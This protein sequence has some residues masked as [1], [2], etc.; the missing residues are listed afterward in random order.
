A[1]SA[2]VV[3]VFALTFA[4]VHGW[5][6]ALFFVLCVT[7]AWLF[8]GLEASR[9]WRRF[10]PPLAKL[11][12]NAG[13]HAGMAVLVPQ[14]A[15]YFLFGIMFGVIR[16]S[17]AMRREQGL[18]AMVIATSMFAVV[19]LNPGFTFPSIE[20]IWQKGAVL[21]GLL[22]VILSSTVVGISGAVV[23]RRLEETLDQLSEKDRLLELQNGQL[24]TEVDLRT[25]D[26]VAAKE[27]AE[28]ANEA[29]SRFLANMSH[30]IRT[31]LNGIV[32][33]AEI[34]DRRTL[35]PRNC[36]LLDI[37]RD[38]G[39][40]LLTIA[41]DVLDVSKIRQGTFR[42]APVVFDPVAVVDSTL[43]LFGPSAAANGLSMACHVEVP[44]GSRAFGD[45][46]RLRQILTNLVA[47]AIKFTAVGGVTV[48]VTAPTGED[49]N[50]SYSV[51]D[52][53][54]GIVEEQLE[55]IFE[56]F[57]Q[58]DDASNRRYEGTGLGLSIAADLSRLMGGHI[59]VASK[60]GVGSTFTV[61]IPAVAVP[62]GVDENMPSVSVD[63]EATQQEP[64]AYVLVAE[65][66]A[67]NQRVVTAMLSKLGYRFDIAA[68]GTEVMERVRAHRPHV[69]LM[70]C[71]MPEM[72]GYEAT[73]QVREYESTS[74]VQIPVIALTANVA[75]GDRDKCLAAG[76]DDYLAKP[77]KI[78]SLG[79]LLQQ[80]LT[81]RV[82]VPKAS[83]VTS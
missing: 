23:R 73:R 34:L 9:R 6:A 40:S 36:E 48:R 33:V 8:V 43:D 1:V 56:A 24:E 74:G 28:A 67:V 17:M 68:N 52:T 79:A 20:T 76:M 41:N 14:A 19:V 61:V 71:H 25:Q 27:E 44:E 42:L 29:K 72:D 21:Y 75:A 35:D 31:P 62:A 45:A 13:I 70:D 32:G 12:T 46:T 50:W 65:D 51:S 47:N 82:A 57:T 3:A 38:S 64:T 10:A 16:A 22:L 83:G 66:N 2:S 55:T 5:H 26:L 58:V 15:W 81:A 53:G 49:Q 80:L 7:N 39:H 30:E 4:D 63:I 54:I 59:D 77:V 69:I 78:E 11:I 37:I 18:A 60:L